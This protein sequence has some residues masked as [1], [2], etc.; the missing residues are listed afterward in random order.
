MF[1]LATLLASI[2]LL[3]ACTSPAPSV[4][5]ASTTQSAPRPSG[6]VGLPNPASVDCARRGGTLQFIDTSDGQI[7]MC[8]LPSGKS[9]EEWAL[10][11]GE[12]SPD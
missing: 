9:C 3:V 5:D 12:C 6:P 10:L 1:R 7:G 8:R 2:F 11:R 4:T